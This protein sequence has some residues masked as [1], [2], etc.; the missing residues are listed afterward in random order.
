LEEFDNEI[1]ARVNT[2]SQQSQTIGGD[3]ATQAVMVV[4]AF[5]AQRDFLGVAAT[6][7][8]PDEATFAKLLEPTGKSIG[9][10]IN[11]RET[12]RGSPHFNHLTAWSEGIPALGWV[13]VTPKPAPHVDQMAQAAEFNLNRVQKD[14]ADQKDWVMNIKELFKAFTAFVKKNHTTGLVWNA[15]GGAA[16]AGAASAAPK[17]APAAAA[18]AAPKP[19]AAAGGAAASKGGLFD[20]V[21]NVTGGLKKVTDD[22]K[23]YK[24]KDRAEAGPIKDAPKGGKTF[25]SLP[26][27]TA[28]FELQGNKWCVEYQQNLEKVEVANAEAKHVV[29]IYG[30]ANTFIQINNKVNSIMIDNCHKVGVVFNNCLATVEIVNS[31]GIKLQVQ[32][33]VPAIAVDKTSGFQVFLSKDSLDTEI[34]TAKS[35]EMNVV[36]PG[37]KEGDDITEISIPEQF[38]SKYDPVT[39]TLKTESVAHI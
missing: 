36:I 20:G 16:S 15:K 21:S 39:K 10:V 4:A 31:K 37:D 2:F 24:Q 34:V 3:C 19:A 23:V 11:F 30:C 8:K 33:R 6:S 5:Q 7:A 28:K 29:Y 12:K 18:A 35:D 9:D 1:M 38:K 25:G 26:K 32:G 22:Q 27:G 13:Q 17:S 14:H